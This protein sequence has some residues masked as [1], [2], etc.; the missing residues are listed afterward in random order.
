[1]EF[2]TLDKMIE[3]LEE[4]KKAYVERMDAQIAEIKRSIDKM[5]AEYRRETMPEA[6]GMIEYIRQCAKKRFEENPV[7]SGFGR[8]FSLGGSHSNFEP[9]YAFEG[10]IDPSLVDNFYEASDRK[11]NKKKII[12]MYQ[13]TYTQYLFLM[14]NAFYLYGSVSKEIREYSYKGLEIKNEISGSIT[15]D[16]YTVKFN[17]EYCDSG[18]LAKF[19]DTNKGL[20]RLLLDIK[21]Y[22][23]RS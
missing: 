20:V 7:P 12:M 15:M 10:D 9:V 2:A 14:E 22:A 5:K 16:T 18:E 8:L 21:D 4:E 17:G 19:L 23:E 6:T 1:M 3:K 13:N 11:I